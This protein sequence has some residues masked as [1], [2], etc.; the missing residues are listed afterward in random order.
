MTTSQGSIRQV[1]PLDMHASFFDDNHPLAFRIMHNCL[2]ADN[3]NS[4]KEGYSQVLI[5]TSK[6][7]LCHSQYAIILQVLY[8]A[9]MTNDIT[10]FTSENLSLEWP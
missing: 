5:A 1:H 7:I 2:S 4:D 9:Q 6:M 10:K 3:I 8:P